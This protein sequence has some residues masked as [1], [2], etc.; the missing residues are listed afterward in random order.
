MEADF[1]S[2]MR[3]FAGSTGK[4]D[5]NFVKELQGLT[6][7]RSNHPNGGSCYKIVQNYTMSY[8]KQIYPTETNKAKDGNTEVE[9]DA[10]TAFAQ[11]NIAV[12]SGLSTSSSSQGL[13][14]SRAV[15]FD[16]LDAKLSAMPS[17]DINLVKELQRIGVNDYGGKKTA[18]DLRFPD[19]S[20]VLRKEKFLSDAVIYYNS[21]Q[22]NIRIQAL[23]DMRESLL[24]DYM[25]S[26]VMSEIIRANRALR[27]QYQ[28]AEYEGSLNDFSK[29]TGDGLL[30]D[31]PYASFTVR[32]IDQNGDE[33]TELPYTV[34]AKGGINFRESAMKTSMGK[35]PGAF[36]SGATL[37]ESSDDSQDG[38]HYLFRYKVND[39][40]PHSGS[41]RIQVLIPEFEKT[42][43]WAN[44]RLKVYG[45]TPSSVNDRSSILDSKPGIILTAQAFRFKGMGTVHE[46]SVPIYREPIPNHLVMTEDGR[47][48][49][50]WSTIE[51]IQKLPRH[52]K[53]V[54]KTKISRLKHSTLWENA[55]KNGDF[56]IDQEE[57][58][59][60]EGE[61]ARQDLNLEQK[62]PVRNMRVELRPDANNSWLS[63][64]VTLADETD[65][66]GSSSITAPVGSYT[67]VLVSQD[68]N[69]EDKDTYIGEIS[70]PAGV[71]Y[72]DTTL[73]DTTP[74]G[75]VGATLSSNTRATITDFKLTTQIPRMKSGMKAESGTVY[76]IKSLPGI[77]T[78][79]PNNAP[80]T[81][82][83]SIFSEFEVLL[84][85]LP[86]EIALEGSYEDMQEVEAPQEVISFN[87]TLSM[88]QASSGSVVTGIDPTPAGTKWNITRIAVSKTSP[89][90]VFENTYEPSESKD[91]FGRENYGRAN[92]IY[93]Q[94]PNMDNGDDYLVIYPA[95]QG[96]IV[97]YPTESV[98]VSTPGVGGGFTYTIEEIVEVEELVENTPAENNTSNALPTPSPPSRIPYDGYY[99]T[100][101]SM[102]AFGIGQSAFKWEVYSS[103][104]GSEP[105]RTQIS[106]MGYSGA[107]SEAREFIASLTVAN[108]SNIANNLINNIVNNIPNNSIMVPATPDVPPAQNYI[109]PI[110][111]EAITQ[112]ENTG[113]AVTANYLSSQAVVNAY[114]AGNL[115]YSQAA[116]QLQQGHGWS[117]TDVDNELNPVITP[118]YTAPTALEVVTENIPNNVS[119][120]LPS[121]IVN[122]NNTVNTPSATY[123]NM[124]A[125]T[126]IANSFAAGNMTYSQAS[127]ALQTQHSWSPLDVSNTLDPLQSAH[128]SA[129]ASAASA[130]AE[131]RR[132]QMIANQQA[133][134]TT[135][136]D[137]NCYITTAV[138]KSKGHDE[139][140]ELQSMR[141][142]RDNY[143]I[144]H[145]AKEV[146]EYYE[147]APLIVS[148]ISK[149]ENGNEVFKELYYKFIMPAHELVKRG[150]YEDAHTVYRNMV[151]KTRKYGSGQ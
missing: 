149:L 127:S 47:L 8:E 116:Q 96:D 88:T 112:A 133:A 26:N 13:I 42:S 114:R 37:F 145:Y 69:G 124:M 70:I 108:T 94:T 34:S 16:D 72:R 140:P 99:Y 57:Y 43:P 78:G 102:A 101:E 80:T 120:G 113:D 122:Q 131:A 85:P 48:V 38:K 132:F 22:K 60:P 66:S 18:L 31:N 81:T 54:L 39:E 95:E 91:Q 52:Q 84:P 2:I 58:Q 75:V 25:E 29:N 32:F 3:G 103:E 62:I 115:T 148:G 30:P 45:G 138:M 142:L 49:S 117:Q 4:Y 118:S 109:D 104:S 151:N 5:W 28:Q 76:A 19:G 9:L 24:T 56:V 123:I 89:A 51:N 14:P 35:N 44:P 73:N 129:V 21:Y 121:T 135:P 83:E 125:T 137:N 27:I 50:K 79:W 98:T 143:G 23:K 65:L 1:T 146:E 110:V 97:A 77:E 90:V 130:A 105:L 106:M 40:V 86:G 67:M 134:N 55:D 139:S 87:Q 59:S 74:I 107:T 20:F 63:A 92:I 93:Q 41:F 36:A 6:L 64:R 128:N 150:K 82:D 15:S 53:I 126:A 33:V 10:K 147:I 111:I 141:A 71:F 119:D 136:T 61:A 144:R 17:F 68:E 46:V 100:V 11:F 7:L 12:S